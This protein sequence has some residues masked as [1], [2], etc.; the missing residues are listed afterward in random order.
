MNYIRGSD[1]M[2][3]TVYKEQFVRKS[4]YIFVFF[5]IIIP[6]IP[7]GLISLSEETFFCFN[8]LMLGFG[9]A[10]VFLSTIYYLTSG[11]KNESLL[12]LLYYL[13][14]CGGALVSLKNLQFHTST[15][16]SKNFPY[17]GDFTQ[18][19]SV[20]LCILMLYLY[21]F[22]EK[23]IEDRF[24]SYIFIIG[25][26]SGIG[27]G[28][29]NN[30]L[31][32][33]YIQYS[34]NTSKLIISVLNILLVLAMVVLSLYKW[35]KS[36]DLLTKYFFIIM[37]LNLIKHIYLISSLGINDT[38]IFIAFSLKVLT[39]FLPIIVFGYWVL[40][41]IKLQKRTYLVYNNTKD[42][43]IKFYGLVESS[44]SYMMILDKEKKID[45]INA[46]FE[47]FIN[48][49]FLDKKQNQVLEDLLDK[50]GMMSF[51]EKPLHYVDNNNYWTGELVLES[52]EGK[53]IYL[54]IK[55]SKI[56]V[57]SNHH[58]GYF[59]ILE[60]NS[61]NIELNNILIEKDNLFNILI[62]NIREMVCTLDL[63]G[64]IRYC[65]PYYIKTFGG[66]FE[67]YKMVPWI[68]NV[69]D[70]DVEKVLKD[71]KEIIENNVTL[72][73]QCRMLDKDKEI[74]YVEYIIT[75][76]LNE[77]GAITEL[78]VSARDISKRKRV[79]TQANNIEEKFV[80]IFNVSPDLILLID[81]D[82]FKVLDV[83]PAFCDFVKMK[84]D[85]I[86]DK[87]IC[88]I[89]R[90]LKW[91]GNKEI[92]QDIKDKKVIKGQEVSF[93]IDGKVKFIEVN[94][95]AISQDGIYE[96]ILC[97]GRDITEKK[98]VEKLEKELDSKAKKLDETLLSDKFRTDFIA[99]VSH[100]LRT[101]INVIFSSLQ[102]LELYKNN[103][104]VLDIFY[105]KYMYVIKQNCYRLLRL[106]NNLIDITK[107]DSGYMK[108]N[109][110]SYDIVKIIEDITMSVVTYGENKGIDIIFDTSEEEIVTNCDPDHIE[111]IMLNLLSN[112][113]KFTNSGGN[114]KVFVNL[115]NNIITIGVR[116]TG[117]GIP[118]NKLNDVFERFKQA[119]RDVI[120]ENEG[121][122]IGLSLVKSLVELH[123][124][125]ITVSSTEGVGS[126]FII[127]IPLCNNILGE[128][129]NIA[130]D[131]EQT[132]IQRISIEF[133]DIYQ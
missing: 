131:R 108:V 79:E 88:K 117:E 25:F 76:V 5:I 71:I 12:I 27:L 67:N 38:L 11:R 44:N 80:N 46:K 102:V 120:R 53:K 112:A 66:E 69:I 116:D 7:K 82:E 109:M 10:S 91:K 49:N 24:F 33:F 21:N 13:I 77:S 70:E 94:Y 125:V 32:D 3:G 35:I 41:N 6:I 48:I 57:A 123:G 17:V 106:I 65:S 103:K 43:F 87:D 19:F 16:I 115:E 58:L 34:N 95:S 54:G 23:S 40:E 60:D 89:L 105:N 8:I 51:L 126:E 84:R 73:S 132:N 4:I 55:I 59:L 78:V 119:G 100:E 107:I 18:L 92:I 81:V 36:G 86:V 20:V 15:Y 122:G 63:E 129:Y 1:E 99:N 45:Y 96:N 50:T 124:G 42:Y 85:K 47:E 52:I 75:P 128:V 26:L 37:V 121:S 68:H 113:I 9:L 118:K 130:K 133:S 14:T 74:I 111:R 22:R 31:F 97:F 98:E 64:R 72:M 127:K 39:R 110:G 30:K 101:P 104:E 56:I 90:K 83:N 62:E 93:T 29:I 114:I 2:S 28:L 61:K